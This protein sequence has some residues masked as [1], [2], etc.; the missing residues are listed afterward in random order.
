M[1]SAGAS[2]INP[3]F[4]AG[5]NQTAGADRVRA[6]LAKSNTPL[7]ARTI[8]PDGTPNADSLIRM[9]V[10]DPVNAGSIS[11]TVKSYAQA[12]VL[13]A[14]PD[15]KSQLCIRVISR[16]GTVVRGTLLA[17]SGAGIGA[18][19][20]QNPSGT[21]NAQFA[22]SGTALSAVTA[23][24]GDRI[25]WEMGVFGI[26]DFGRNQKG[27]IYFGD[28]T[29]TADLP[30]NETQTTL[31]DP[32]IEFSQAISMEP[33]GGPPPPIPGAPVGGDFTTPR[34]EIPWE[35]YLCDSFGDAIEDITHVMVGKE[36][37]CQRNRPAFFSGEV[38]SD[39]EKINDLYTD[40]LPNLEAEVRT[41]KA[42]RE[43]LVDQVVNW[44][45]NPSFETNAAGLEAVGVGTSVGQAGVPGA[46]GSNAGFIAGNGAALEQYGYA[47]TN[48]SGVDDVLGFTEEARTFVGSLYLQTASGT[49]LLRVTTVVVYT[50]LTETAS[51]D[52]LVNVPGA[53]T[54]YETAAV[55]IDPTKV[56]DE[57]RIKVGVRSGVTAAFTVA[58]DGVLIEEA[59]GASTYVDGANGGTW[60][61]TAHAS[62]TIQPD[63]PTWVLRFNGYI[64]V[65]EDGDNNRT[66]IVA[67]DP[68]RYAHE[69]FAID[70]AGGIEIVA[71][72]GDEAAQI[73]RI[74]V[75][76]QNVL[77]TTGI[78]TDGEF[79]TTATRIVEFKRK[80]M[81]EALIELAEADLGF[82]LYFAPVDRD[83]GYLVSM[84]CF[85][86]LGE[87]RPDCIFRWPGTA[88][89][90]GRIRDG[91][92]L[93]NVLY[94]VGNQI[95]TAARTDSASI[96]KYRR[97]E[98]LVNFPDT[99]DL[100]Y[101]EAQVDGELTLRK[102]M[103]ERVTFRPLPGKS[104]E[105]WTHFFVGDYIRSEA[106]PEKRGG[107]LRTERVEAFTVKILDGTNHERLDTVTVRVDD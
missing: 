15:G 40:G 69:R 44:H 72:E 73:A 34:L 23:Q 59:Q 94:G 16:D 14:F 30:E 85:Q 33:G 76:R 99:V 93:G 51:A 38:R 58:L 86:Q 71:F 17:L 101:L 49:P 88:A 31:G 32:W 6:V 43:E 63:V 61:G 78:V 84:S 50:D 24:Q 1:P 100:A 25:V 81:G 18:N 98:K 60:E 54:R 79:H 11:G 87:D 9:Y 42:Y 46:F 105:P 80:M 19:W 89:A 28:P 52:L 104:P 97:H 96:T 62:R 5:W 36:T 90:A 92:K 77:G 27:R 48:L 103:K 82:D 2:L 21:R 20:L 67:Y 102:E 106:A 74:L 66:K 95:V 47:T 37:G 13:S 64:E 26:S 29:A 35:V 57:I 39:E 45:Q 70:S 55:T 3:A 68:L 22:A 12:N 41:L 107:W 8:T 7:A 56:V 91:T 10:S 53:W 65:V 75:D 83:D 4:S